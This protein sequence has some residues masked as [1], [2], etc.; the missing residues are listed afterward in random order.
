MAN[1]FADRESSSTDL[2]TNRLRQAIQ[3]ALRR[4]RRGHR[5]VAFSVYN[6][7]FVRL[8]RFDFLK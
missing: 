8:D 6:F 3:K 4:I 7:T 2:Q 5:P 1:G